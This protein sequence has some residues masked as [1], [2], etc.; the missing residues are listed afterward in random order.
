MFADSTLYRKNCKDSLGLHGILVFSKEVMPD[1]QPPSSIKEVP[2]AIVKNMIVLAASGFGVVVALAWNE[3]IKQ[4][5]AS[6]IDPYLGKSGTL[7]SLF[8]YA[9]A[10][11]IMAVIVTMQLTYLQKT[12]EQIQ[13][14]VSKRN[15]ETKK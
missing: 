7:L 3:A 11:T 8:I 2:L 6:Y 9:V 1:I 14:R 13:E 12:L 10:I 15:K 4:F 5:I